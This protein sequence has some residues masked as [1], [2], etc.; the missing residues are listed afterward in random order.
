MTRR[1][2]SKIL[3]RDERKAEI[4]KFVLTR[5]VTRCP[6]ACVAETQASPHPVDRAALAEYAVLREAQR[7][8]RLARL[9][10]RAIAALG[11]ASTSEDSELA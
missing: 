1:R 11:L 8:D 10:S 2:V 5:K 7:R 9:R 4:D 6:T 3:R